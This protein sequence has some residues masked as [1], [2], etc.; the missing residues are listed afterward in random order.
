MN[1][2]KASPRFKI[3]KFRPIGSKPIKKRVEISIPP[4]LSTSLIRTAYHNDSTSPSHGKN[5]K[6][7]IGK[8]F[9]ILNEKH[10]GNVSLNSS[11]NMSAK[12]SGSL[13]RTQLVHS[14]A[15]NRSIGTE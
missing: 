12:L 7:K 8:G 11:L 5:S 4:K 9:P 10:S 1:A 14:L 13:N 2:T 15:T 3:L 6:R